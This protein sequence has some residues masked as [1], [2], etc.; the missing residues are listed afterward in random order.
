MNIK[1]AKVQKLFYILKFIFN[2]TPTYLIYLELNSLSLSLR[3]CMLLYLLKNTYTFIV[4]CLKIVF[5]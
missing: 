1:R 3:N 5:N 2:K 4:I